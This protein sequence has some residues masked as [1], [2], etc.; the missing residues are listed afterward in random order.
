MGKEHISDIAEL[1]KECF[2]SPWSESSL[3]EELYNDNAIFVVAC[4][5]KEILGYCGMHLIFGEG[6][7]TNIAVFNKHR[8][9]G[10]AKA[11]LNHLM[12]FCDI[13]LSLEVRENNLSA[14]CLYQNL[15][16]KQEGLRKNFYSNPT[17]NALIYTYRR[18]G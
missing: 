12:P 16:F 3:I 18:R 10:V 11:L 2:S 1:E 14:V 13:S 9:K 5:D 7:I 15:G 6:Y 17:E 8:R 4:E